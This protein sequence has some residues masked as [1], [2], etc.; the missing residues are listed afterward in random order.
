MRF[1]C[2]AC[3][4]FVSCGSLRKVSY[5]GF[6]QPASTQEKA[7]SEERL[8]LKSIEVPKSCPS[9]L[10][11]SFSTVIVDYVPFPIC[12]ETYKASFESSINFL[13]IDERAVLE[14]VLKSNCR[15]LGW[16]S[17]GESLE[18]ILHNFD[19]TG[20]I[21]RRNEEFQTLISM[22]S[23]AKTLLELK[24]NIEEI[25]S[26]HIPLDRWVRA[27]GQMIVPEIY[28]NYI[29]TM[30]EKNKCSIVE[31]QF[32]EGF[33]LVKDLQELNGLMVSSA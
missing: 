5:V 28:L 24:K 3:L 11:K 4:L 8:N 15:S 19:T 7:I 22:E 25:V 1:L 21:G 14:E 18:S 20:P 33:Q 9:E 13:K 2:F 29:Q 6:R 23:E 27:H 10:K 30:I 16:G 12:P 17:F 31:D 32:D 26:T